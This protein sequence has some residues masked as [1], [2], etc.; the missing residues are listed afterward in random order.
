MAE[1]NYWEGLTTHIKKGQFIG[2]QKFTEHSFCQK[3]KKTQ[4]LSLYQEFN[5]DA[6]QYRR[7]ILCDKCWKIFHQETNLKTG[8]E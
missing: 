6:K 2:H 5:Y 1:N 4:D 8:K 7:Y 3:C